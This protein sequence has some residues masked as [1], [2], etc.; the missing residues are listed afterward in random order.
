[1]R[2][3]L[4]KPDLLTPKVGAESEGGQNKLF[5]HEVAPY[6]LCR[7]LRV[8]QTMFLFQLNVPF[9]LGI[10]TEFGSE[11]SNLTSD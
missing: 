1:M 11:L 2:Y 4:Y 7:Y 5:T 6:T 8:I 9:W 10:P 3:A